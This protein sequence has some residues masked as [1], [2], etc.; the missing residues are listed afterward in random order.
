ALHRKP[1][2]Y[3]ARVDGDWAEVSISSDE[4]AVDRVK[5]VREDGKWRVVLELPPLAPIERRMDGGL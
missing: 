5:C 3:E 1:R 2:Q 4:G